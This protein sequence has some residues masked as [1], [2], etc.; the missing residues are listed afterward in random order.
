M[1][2]IHFFNSTKIKISLKQKLLYIWFYVGIPLLY[3]GGESII[4]WL[5]FSKNEWVYREVMWNMYVLHVIL[6]SFFLWWFA[7]FAIKKVKHQ[8]YINRLR[9]KYILF[10]SYIFVFL[11][12]LFQLFLPLIWIRIFEKELILLFV[13][14][15]LSIVYIVKRYYFANVS[16]SVGKFVMRVSSMLWAAIITIIVNDYYVTSNHGY[17]WNQEIDSFLNLIVGI[18][19]YICIYNFLWKKI[20]GNYMKWELKDMIKKLEHHISFITNRDELNHYL[21]SEI[22]KI[23]KTNFSEIKIFCEYGEKTQLQKYF[24]NELSEKIFINDIVFIEEKK[25]KFQKEILLKEIQKEAFLIFP[26]SNRDRKISWVFMV[27]S[28]NFWDFYDIDE[29]HALKDFAS[30]LEYHIKYIQNYEQIKDLSVNLDKKIDVKTIE[31]NNLINK[32]KEFISMISHEIKSPLS[33][34]IFQSDSIIDDIKAGEKNMDYILKEVDILSSVLIRIWELTNKLFSVQYYDTHTI[35]LYIED[36][37]I[38]NLLINELLIFEHT[39]ENITFIDNIDHN[40]WFIKLDKIQ[41]IQVIQ[42]IMSNAIKFVN[43]E[44]WIICITA[45]IIENTFHVSIEDNWEWF[46]G[47]DVEKIFDKYSTTSGNYAWLGM[48]LYLCKKIVEMH[49]GKIYGEISQVYG[50]AKFSIEIPLQ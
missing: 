36:I 4:A 13:F 43:K 10:S 32:Q 27:G 42:N 7:Y 48:W 15:I 24:E 21:H 5:E 35:E 14:Y 8:I 23:F 6:Q 9:L 46:H 45:Q 26:L 40:M 25:T 16:Y 2:S 41:F 19:L 29:I 49:H 37:H 1:F 38:V 17:W 22:Q 28:K 31:Y 20:L 50:W 30:F 39:N 47:I 44:R 34:A 12:I 3:V 33:S 11:L 18:I